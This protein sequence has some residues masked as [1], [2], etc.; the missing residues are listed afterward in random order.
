MAHSGELGNWYLR[1]EKSDI[2]FVCRWLALAFLL[3]NSNHMVYRNDCGFTQAIGRS[4][5]K[6]VKAVC[7]NPR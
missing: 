7:K 2:V 4:K 3:V 6:G 5:V 1:V